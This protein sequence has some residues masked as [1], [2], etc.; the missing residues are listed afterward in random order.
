MAADHIVKVGPKKQVCAPAPAGG[1]EPT[2]QNEVPDRRGRSIAEIPGRFGRSQIAR[3]FVARVGGRGEDAA[4]AAWVRS[5]DRRAT[6][7]Y[8]FRKPDL[9]RFPVCRAFAHRHAA[10]CVTLA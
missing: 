3:A 7:R 6:D 8:L 10:F 1:N 9:I 5:T 4:W 2:G